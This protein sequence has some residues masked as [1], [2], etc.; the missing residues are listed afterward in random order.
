VQRRERRSPPAHSLRTRSEPVEP[1]DLM[2]VDYKGQFLL[3]NHCY[4]QRRAS[5]RGARPEAAGPDLPA[6]ATA[7]Q[8]QRLQ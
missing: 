4:L 8:H 7:A 1:A 6:I 5:A 2:T 3:G